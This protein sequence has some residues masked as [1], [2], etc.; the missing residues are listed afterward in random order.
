MRL[1][2]KVREEERKELP[3]VFRK[4]VLKKMEIQNYSFLNFGC[5]P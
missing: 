3:K 1:R 4:F 2:E 5:G